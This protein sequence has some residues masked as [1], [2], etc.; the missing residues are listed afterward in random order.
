MPLSRSLRSIPDLPGGLLPDWVLT[1]QSGQVGTGERQIDGLVP[2]LLVP[3]SVLMAISSNK[4]DCLW[5]LHVEAVRTEVEPIAAANSE[6]DIDKVMDAIRKRIFETYEPAEGPFLE[7]AKAAA[8]VVPSELLW[9]LHE[10]AIHTVANPIAAANSELDI[11]EV[12]GAIRKQVFETYEPA[13]GPFLEFSKAAAWEK[14]LFVLLWTSATEKL[15]RHVRWIVA[16]VPDSDENDVLQHVWR[17]VFAGYDPKAGSFISFA[18][19]AARNRALDLVRSPELVRRLDAEDA[20]IEAFSEQISDVDTR[21]SRW[22]VFNRFA[23]LVFDGSLPPEQVI[24][25]GYCRLLEYK[26]RE[27]ITPKPAKE[28]EPQ[29]KD[30][31]PYQLAELVDMFEEEYA[32]KSPIPIETISSWLKPLRDSFLGKGS[33]GITPLDNHFTSTTVT[34]QRA[35]VSKWWKHVEMVA[36]RKIVFDLPDILEDLAESPLHPHEIVAY[37]CIEL[38]RMYPKNVVTSCATLVL[39][40][41]LARI[42]EGCLEQLRARIKDE[43]QEQFRAR[44]KEECPEQH[45]ARIEKECLEQ[46]RKRAPAIGRAFDELRNK[47]LRPASR[48]FISE[49]DKLRYKNLLQHDPKLKETTLGAY[50][51]GNAKK[52]DIIEWRDRVK[53][54]IRGWLYA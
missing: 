39:P 33:L 19:R 38:L 30:L 23:R 25:F 28:G 44:V 36:M 45:R 41:L 53:R 50:F 17:K 46:F 9:A 14:V 42:E 5:A 21:I 11:V 48:E 16:S 8:S 15:R 40:K 20:D 31:R 35:E 43:C 51:G 32:W 27:I 13:E 26:P 2:P 3:Y 10:S 24:I 4:F 1:S 6:L 52:D 37:G 22:Q 29:D 34:G 54:Y 12:M 49:T 47:L 7:F 18:K